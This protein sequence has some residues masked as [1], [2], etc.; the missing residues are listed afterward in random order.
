M[1]FAEEV[2][3]SNE[4]YSAKNWQKV[5]SEGLG[6]WGVSFAV[7]WNIGSLRGFTYLCT[8][9]K[10]SLG[11]YPLSKEAKINLKEEYMIK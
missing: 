11:Y 8:T 6:F 3:F 2:Y 4:I 1:F 9:I 7:R 5:R 10:W